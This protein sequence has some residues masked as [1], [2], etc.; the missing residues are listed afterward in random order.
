MGISPSAKKGARILRVLDDDDERETALGAEITPALL[1]REKAR[2]RLSRVIGYPFPGVEARLSAGTESGGGGG[3][4]MASG[5]D[6]DNMLDSMPDW[7][8]PFCSLEQL[9]WSL[10]LGDPPLSED[11]NYGGE[12]NTR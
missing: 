5:T 11:P 8:W 3:D 10:L 7:A 9:D 4:S 12:L 6:P 2:E 1:G